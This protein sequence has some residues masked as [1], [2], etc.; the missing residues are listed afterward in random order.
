M[1]HRR[2]IGYSRNEQHPELPDP[3]A[4]VDD[5]WDDA[6]RHAVWSYFCS[7]TVVVAYMGNSPCRLCGQDNGSLEYTDGVY[8]W[9]EGL[10]HYVSDHGVRLPDEVVRHAV[11]RLGELKAAD[12]S[13]DWWLAATSSG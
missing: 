6:E 7:G 4:C 11:A 12:S 8:Q 10:A 3:R 5:S 9:P 13:L 1:D 2:L